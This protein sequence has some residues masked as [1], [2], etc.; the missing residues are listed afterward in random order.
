MKT[1][2]GNNFIKQITNPE[3]QKMKWIQK[4]LFIELLK[5][6]IMRIGSIFLNGI[7][8]PE[9]IKTYLQIQRKYKIKHKGLLVLIEFFGDTGVLIKEYKES[10]KN[11]SLEREDDV[12]LVSIKSQKINNNLKNSVRNNQGS[13]DRSY[14]NLINYSVNHQT[15]KMSPLK[16]K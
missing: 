2:K 4:T 8:K 1:G 13:L 12:D 3:D 16:K 5:N 14:K 6:I 11:R 15:S 10:N 7:L 9:I